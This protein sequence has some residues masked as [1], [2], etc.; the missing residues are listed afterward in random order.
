M[1]RGKLRLTRD[2]DGWYEGEP[3]TRKQIVA[4]IQRIRRRTRVHP[5]RV[6]LLAAAITSLISWKL[7]TRPH[8]FESEVVLLLTEGSLSAKHPAVP[9]EELHGWVYDV[10]LPN[11]RLAQLIDD[12][13]MYRIRR[14]FS[15]EDAIAELRENIEIEIWK[16]TFV[17]YD[18]DEGTEAEH[19]ARIG[20]TYTDTDRDRAAQI[21]HELAEI[22][23]S[24]GF[25]L[26]RE[27]NRQLSKSAAA[28]RKSLTGRMR[29]LTLERAQKDQAVKL[30]LHDGKPALA[31]ALDLAIV[32]LDAELKNIQKELLDVAGGRDLYAEQIANNG[33]DM[34]LTIAEERPPDHP[35]THLFTM[36][37]VVAIVA[38][39]SLFGSALLLG[40]FDS[41]VHETD[42][43]ERLGLPVLGH[44]P[45]FPGDRVGA[46]CVRGASRSHGP[47]FRRWLP[48]K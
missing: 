29:A 36:L 32:S 7:L 31:R 34:S 10:L 21:S 15:R 33:L 35:E 46:L 5:F 18:E 17:N 22:I 8:A 48:L 26:R 9:V 12:H 40:A 42:D 24:E 38:F 28:V 44:L 19:S 37:V 20:L 39:G 13:H 4:E 27:L 25:D 41:R 3:S 47:M 30:A 2:N 6:L 1:A 16:N 11:D 43:I 45:P 14:A 23:I